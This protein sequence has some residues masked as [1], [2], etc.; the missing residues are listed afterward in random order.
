MKREHVPVPVPTSKF[1][2]VKCDEC[3]ETQIIYSH[4]T[5]LVTCNS[6]GNEVATPTG[7]AAELKGKKLDP[8]A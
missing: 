3:G 5:S 6:C 1:N 4:A 8:V 2:R 7:S